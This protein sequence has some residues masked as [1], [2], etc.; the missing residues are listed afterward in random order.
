MSVR[1]KEQCKERLQA[2][3]TLKQGDEYQVLEDAFEAYWDSLPEA[4][5]IDADNIAATIRRHRPKK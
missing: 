4:E 1:L 3:A 5:Q 2:V